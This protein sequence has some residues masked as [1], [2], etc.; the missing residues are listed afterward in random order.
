MGVSSLWLGPDHLLLVEGRGYTERYRRFYYR[1]IAS[2]VSRNTRSFAVGIVVLA[3]LLALST[4]A[5]ATASVDIRP[6]LLVVA[7]L[8]AALALAIHVIKGP[9]CRSEIT[10]AIQTAP[11]PFRRWRAARKSIARIRERVAEAQPAPAAPA[12]APSAAAV[13]PQQ[14]GPAE[15]AP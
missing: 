12:E 10:T 14:A 7:V 3:S 9:S 13:E 8:P 5:V 11:L 4:A 15:P 1:D 2:I 6:Y